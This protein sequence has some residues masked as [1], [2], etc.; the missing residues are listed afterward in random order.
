MDGGGTWVRSS[1]VGL[2]GAPESLFMADARHGWALVGMSVCCFL[3]D[4]ALEELAED[5]SEPIPGHDRA[6]LEKPPPR[7]LPRLR[8]VPIKTRRGGNLQ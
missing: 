4:P 8:V 3:G 5:L 6:V 7:R 1:A 2:P